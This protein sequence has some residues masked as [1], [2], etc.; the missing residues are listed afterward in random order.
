[1]EDGDVSYNIIQIVADD[2]GFGDIG[3]FNGGLTITPNIDRLFSGGT[4]FGNAYSASPVC[5]PA[6]AALLTGRY[7]HRTGAIDTLEGLG[8][9]RLALDERTI[10][11][12]FRAHGYRTGLIGKWH[13]GALD[14]RYHPHRRGFE[15][16]FGF[17]GGW[18]DYWKW[19]LY[20]NDDVVPSDGRYLTDV[21]GEA[22]RAFVSA[23][24]DRPFY[25]MLAFNAPHYPLQAHEADLASVRQRKPDATDEVATIYAMVEAMDR[26]IGEVLA[27]LEQAGRADKTIVLFTSDN[28]PE[29]GKG[30]ARPNLEFRGYKTKVWEG[31]IRVPFAMYGPGIV[32][33]GKEVDGVLHFIDLLPT[34]LDACSVAP[35]EGGLPIDGVSRWTSLSDAPP[36]GA[37]RYWQWNRY[38]PIETCNSAVREG[39]WKLVYPEIPAAMKMMPEDVEMDVALK[40]QPE[41]HPTIRPRIYRADVGD[42]N[43]A[44]LFD[45][46]SDPHEQRNLTTAHPDVASRLASQLHDWFVEVE[47]DRERT[48][49]N[50]NPE[51]G[52]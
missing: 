30:S 25:L 6:R 26:A 12:A 29:L 5:A 17:T 51:V 41:L 7:P 11:D 47:R 18:M 19:R 49:D 22:G 13:N 52:R 43:P 44:Q 23:D 34:L 2:L 3:Y 46:A 31:G 21:W 37:P 15:H 50:T 42:D 14:P 24:D 45:L 8:L 27:T 16:F 10:A 9:D 40:Y 39:T 33:A 48:K 36:D 28:G 38:T 1:L 20:R 4:R 35:P 32:P